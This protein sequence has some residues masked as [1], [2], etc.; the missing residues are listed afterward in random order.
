MH[1]SELF[2]LYTPLA[3]RDYPHHQLLDALPPFPQRPR[4]TQDQKRKRGHHEHRKQNRVDVEHREREHNDHVVAQP[5]KLRH[6]DLA[7]LH[8]QRAVLPRRLRALHVL[9]VVERVL[10]HVDREGGHTEQVLDDA[11]EDDGEQ[12]DCDGVHHFHPQRPVVQPARRAVGRAPLVLQDDVARKLDV[13]GA[14][15]DPGAGAVAVA[16]ELV[17]QIDHLVDVD[18]RDLLAGRLV[19][20]VRRKLAEIAPQPSGT[21]KKRHIW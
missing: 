20:V 16:H 9:N 15:T 18:L 2:P 11:D 21:A 14:H 5:R 10:Y 6:Q 1:T 3:V 8:Q 13:S 4:Q 7:K 17:G 19:R 12:R